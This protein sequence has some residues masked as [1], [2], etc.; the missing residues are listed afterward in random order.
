M[1]TGIQGKLAVNTENFVIFF[2]AGIA[3]A[4]YPV[5]LLPCRQITEMEEITL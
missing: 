2:V 5:W 4:N 3:V 1:Q